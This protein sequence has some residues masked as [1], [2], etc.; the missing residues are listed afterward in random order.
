MSSTKPGRED[1]TTIK[2]NDA[3]ELGT[4]TVKDLEPEKHATAIRGGQ[5]RGTI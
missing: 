5:S 1:K 3:L 4:E 2:P